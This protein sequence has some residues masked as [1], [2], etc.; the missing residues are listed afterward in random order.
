M[1]VRPGAKPGAARQTDE[2]PRFNTIAD[3]HQ[4]LLHMGVDGFIPI[5]MGDTHVNAVGA[6]TLDRLHA[7]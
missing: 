3:A 5:G 4:S 6:V 2:R 7:A 1:Q